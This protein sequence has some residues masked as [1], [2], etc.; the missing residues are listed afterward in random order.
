MYTRIFHEMVLEMPYE[1][2]IQYFPSGGEQGAIYL[3]DVPNIEKKLDKM[4][5]LLANIEK[6]NDVNSV[7]SFLPFFEAFARIVIF[8]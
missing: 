2:N 4:K 8:H 7:N 6:E 5:Q 1:A 3:T